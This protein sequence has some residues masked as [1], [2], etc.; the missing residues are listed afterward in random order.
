MLKGFFSLTL[1]FPH[2]LWH[3]FESERCSD[4]MQFAHCVR[5]CPFHSTS[6]KRHTDSAA[7]QLRAPPNN[8]LMGPFAARLWLCLRW[9]AAAFRC[10]PNRHLQRKGYQQPIY[11][12]TM[13]WR[14]H[15]CTTSAAT[16]SLTHAHAPAAAHLYACGVVL[17]GIHCFR[18]YFSLRH[19]LQNFKISLNRVKLG[20]GER[21]YSIKV[22]CTHCASV[23]Q[24]RPT[25][26]LVVVDQVSNPR[27]FLFGIV[28]RGRLLLSKEWFVT[29][30][31]QFVA[32]LGQLRCR[33][34]FSDKWRHSHC[35]MWP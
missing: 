25:A 9:L 1:N 35:R 15:S 18:L 27:L 11:T 2:L 33:V 13:V 14:F 20:A 30:L 22:S 29:F 23:K 28:A 6:K 16:A 8:L 17:R 31:A 24:A 19:L 12:E 26:E 34:Y 32:F 10:A 3:S 5:W 4:C 21:G 7:R